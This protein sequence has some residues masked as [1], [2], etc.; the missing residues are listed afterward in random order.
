MFK[1]FEKIIDALLRLPQAVIIALLALSFV[2]ANIF[3]SMQVAEVYFSTFGSINNIVAVFVFGLAF[4]LIFELF[5]MIYFRLVKYMIVSSEVM[6]HKRNM[7]ITL[8][9]FYFVINLVSGAV[10]LLYFSNPLTMMLIENIVVFTVE[11]GML[12]LFYFYVRKK[13]VPPQLYPRSIVAFCVPYLLFLL[14]NLFSA[15]II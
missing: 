8:R 9:W 14:L 7:L 11:I 2:F 1:F 15:A 10:R 13:Y 5:A 4:W 3:D 12:T 6:K